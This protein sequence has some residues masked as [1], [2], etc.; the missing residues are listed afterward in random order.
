MTKNYP[1]QKKSF[2]KNTRLKVPGFLPVQQDVL[3]SVGIPWFEDREQ[4]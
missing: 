1:H 3:P 4:G 2:K